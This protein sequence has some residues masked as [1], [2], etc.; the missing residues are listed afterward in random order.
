MQADFDHFRAFYGYRLIGLRCRYVV[1]GS[2][3]DGRGSGK[4]KHPLRV[5]LSDIGYLDRL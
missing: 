2:D 4:K 3:G 1:R 5:L